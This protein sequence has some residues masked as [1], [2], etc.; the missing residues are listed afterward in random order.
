MDTKQITVACFSGGKDSTAMILAMMERGEKIDG[1]L[2][3]PTGNELPEVWDHW[4]N[5]SK[6]VGAPTIRPKGPSLA[7][8]IT[9]F[10]ALPNF[11]QRWCTRMIK[12]QPAIAW[13][14]M[15]PGATLC[16]GLRADEEERAGIISTSVAS[17][18]P[19]REYGMGLREVREV[20]NAYGIDGPKRTGCPI[21]VPKRTDC[22]ICY[23]QRL[24]EWFELWQEHPDLWAQ[25]EAWEAQTGH[26]FR[27]P[28]RDTWPVS[29]TGLREA[30][31]A[32]REPTRSLK[33]LANSRR[34]EDDE[35]TC[36]VCSM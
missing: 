16:V 27:S 13:A 11:R 34:A 4:A 5:V 18:F 17:R 28:G 21:K 8:L 29:M 30:F 24:G 15:N 12:I 33:M 26:T 1:L 9:H 2:V 20:I 25:G 14:K 3:T 7:D 23:H 31:E 35:G 22:D 10:D 6:L 19:L 36:R 32:G